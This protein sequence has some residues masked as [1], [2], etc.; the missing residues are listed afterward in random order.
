MFQKYLV[1][2]C[3]IVGLHYYGK[4]VGSEDFNFKKAGDSQGG[5]HSQ[6]ATFSYDRR[7]PAD[8]SFPS[9]LTH[10]LPATLKQHQTLFKGGSDSGWLLK[11]RMRKFQ[12]G[13]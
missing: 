10:P 11:T 2:A 5:W 3:I 1:K 13:S 8:K 6:A 7:R 12:H 9:A 4:L